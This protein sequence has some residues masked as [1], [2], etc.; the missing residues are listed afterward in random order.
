MMLLRTL[1]LER[2]D[3]GTPV[4]GALLCGF[5]VTQT[6][7]NFLVYS[8]AIPLSLRSFWPVGCWREVIFPWVV[9]SVYLPTNAC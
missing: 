1:V 2:N 6:A 8:L 7:S 9:S 4:N 3:E 5:A